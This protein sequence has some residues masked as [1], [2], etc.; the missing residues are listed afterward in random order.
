[1]PTLLN[2]P[3][4]PNDIDDITWQWNNRLTTGETISTF[5]AVVV[6]GDITVSTSSI[7]GTNTIAR[8]TGGTANTPA[9]VRGRIVTSTARQ[10]DWTVA[11]YVRE[12]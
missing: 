6:S 5:T 8:I 7:S 9:S 12:Q 3:K 11:L 2:T 4:D 1:M 10:L